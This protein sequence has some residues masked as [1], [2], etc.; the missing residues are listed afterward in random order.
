MVRTSCL[1]GDG[2]RVGGENENSVV[3]PGFQCGQPTVFGIIGGELGQ[4]RR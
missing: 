1:I 3:A 4:D 2:C